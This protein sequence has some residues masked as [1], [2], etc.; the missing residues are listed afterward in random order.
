MGA[1]I[2]QPDAP[3]RAGRTHGG[4]R[5]ALRFHPAFRVDRHHGQ[6]A[7]VERFLNPLG[8]VRRVVACSQHFILDCGGQRLAEE[9]ERLDDAFRLSGK[10]LE[11]GLDDRRIGERE[12]GEKEHEGRLLLDHKPDPKET[13]G[14]S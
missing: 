10:R 6:H 1:G 9:V 8:A 4:A 13:P 7:R 3:K 12:R 11:L 5:P 2:P 14:A